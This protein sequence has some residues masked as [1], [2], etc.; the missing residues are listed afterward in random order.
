MKRK[1]F[2]KA[3]LKAID[4]ARD[5]VWIGE[6]RVSRTMGLRVIKRFE[7]V[8]NCAFDPFNDYHVEL[9]HGHASNELFFKKMKQNN[10]NV[11]LHG[12]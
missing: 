12:L 6:D 10:C 2:V 11:T 9:V 4:V 7:R 1:K 3:M 5:P 8:N